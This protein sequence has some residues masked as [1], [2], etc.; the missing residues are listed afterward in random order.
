M[1]AVQSISSYLDEHAQEAANLFKSVVF[2]TL[3]I[4]WR[5]RARHGCRS[6]QP[7][8]ATGSARGTAATVESAKATPSPDYARA[9]ETEPGP[10][11]HQ[12]APAR[13]ISV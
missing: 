6:R 12:R 2:R 10:P 11:R 13:G 3:W 1:F 8:K 9:S 4:L 7:I 5:S